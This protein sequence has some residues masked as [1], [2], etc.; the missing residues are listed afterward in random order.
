MAST[1]YNIFGQQQV[2]TAVP[3]NSYGMV[4]LDGV[5]YIERFQIFA[6]QVTITQPFQVITNLRLTMPGVANFLLKGLARMVTIPPS[7][8]G[9][10]ERRFR[11]RMIGQEASAWFFSSGLGVFDDRVYDNICFGSG[12]FPYMLIPP[13]PIHATGSLIYEIE[14]SGIGTNI[15][16]TYV[17]YTIYLAFIGSYLIPA[18]EPTLSQSFYYSVSNGG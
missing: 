1:A 10:P 8:I 5:Q 18:N 12:Q 3:A 4:T 7:S 16:I 15:E 2:V 6:D 13:V 17:P 9:N 11:F 14:D